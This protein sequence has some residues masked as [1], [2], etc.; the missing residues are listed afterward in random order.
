[1]DEA[2]KNPATTS[3]EIHQ[4]GRTLLTMKQNA[5]ALKVFQ[6]NAERNGDA[7]PVHVGLM[8][9]YAANGDLQKALEHAKKAAAQA[10]DDLNKKNLEAMVKTLEAGKNIE[11]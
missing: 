4:Y 1:M 7:W 3:L 2:I 5:E 11:Q 8:R 9:G 6:L 10:P